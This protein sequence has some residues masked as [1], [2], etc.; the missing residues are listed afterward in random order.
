MED[1]YVKM[2]IDERTKLDISSRTLC[3]GICSEDMYY[4]VESG[5]SSMDR[6]SIKR[7]LSRLGIDNGDYEHYI[8]ASDYETWTK[9]MKLINCVED[10]DIEKAKKLLKEYSDNLDDKRSK[11]KNTSRINIEEQF[12]QFMK[13]QIMRIENKKEYEENAKQLYE[14]AVKMTVPRIDEKALDKFVLS[15]LEM[16]LVLEYKSRMVKDKSYIDK[17]NIYRELLEYITNV[18]FGKLFQTKIYAKLVV[19]MYRDLSIHAQSMSGEELKHVYEEMLKYC[20]HGFEILRQR[21]SMIYMLELLEVRENILSWLIENTI[22]EETVGTY[23]ELKKQTSMYINEIKD[24]YYSYNMKPYMTND[25]YF[26]RESGIYCINEV[27]KNRREILK[28]TQEKMADE[29]LS[30]LTIKRLESMNM[31][32]STNKFK[33][34]FDKLSL[35]PSYVNMGVITDKKDAVALYEELRFAITRFD[36]ENVE[37]IIGSLRE[38]LSEHRLNIQVIGSTEC[39]NEWRQGKISNEQYIDK[40][41]SLLELTISLENIRSSKKIFLTTEELTI[42]LSISIA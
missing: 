22:E 9:R 21:K 25:C 16:N 1:A 35:Y 37:R 11:V 27:S 4:K 6:I 3:E 31:N 32:V 33:K 19:Y 13:L 15:P 28:L 30:V 41:I 29:D 20:E 14:K 18:R 5:K 24:I 2:L 26:Y 23:V 38:I 7:L 36:Y 40:L 12:K 10:G 34:I 42:L 39:L 17:I 8:A